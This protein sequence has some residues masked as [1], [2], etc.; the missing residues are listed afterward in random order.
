MNNTGAP[1]TSAADFNAFGYDPYG[2]IAH[3]T[4]HFYG[5][6]WRPNHPVQQFIGRIKP[7]RYGPPAA[8]QVPFL[9]P[10][11]QPRTPPQFYGES[12]PPYYSPPKRFDPSLWDGLR[13]AARI[14]N[15]FAQL[16][17]DVSRAASSA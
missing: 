5:P 4:G 16:Q 15:I 1:N 14:Q 11:F 9:P 3:V 7:P 17:S 10:G 8:Y 12:F 2:F 6:H 13:F